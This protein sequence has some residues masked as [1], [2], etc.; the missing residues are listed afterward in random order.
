MRSRI[1]TLMFVDMVGYSAMMNADQDATIQAVRE[2]KNHQ[3]EPVLSDFGGE[4]LK[5]MGDGWIIAF[6]SISAALDSAIQVQTNLYGHRKLKLRIGCHLGEIVEDEDDFYGAGVNITQRIQTEAPPGGVMVS[7]DL[8][9]QLSDDRAKLLNE[10]GTFNLK[11]ISQPV[12]LYQ[13]RP[14]PGSQRKLDDV[15]SIAVQAF[16]FAPV[17]AETEAIAGDLRDQLIVRVSRRKGVLVFDALSKAVDK[18][19]YDLRGRVRMA[20]GR[21]RFTITMTS[22]EDARPVW[23]QTYEAPT[24]DVFAFCDEVLELAEGDLRLQTN[25]F[26][27]D[28]LV[29]IPLEELSVSE[30]RARAANEYYK[31]TMESWSYGLALMERAISLNPL[32]GVSL[33]MRVEAQIMLFG[34]RYQ[35]LPIEL[36]AAYKEDLDTAV[37]QSPQSDY[38]FWTRAVFRLVVLDDVEGA[39]ADLKRSAELNPAY[40]ENYELEG[41]IAMREGDFDG[42]DAAFSRLIERGAQNP[43]QPYRLFMRGVARFC[44]GNYEGAAQDAST[45]SD[46]RPNEA[47]HLKLR[48]M[49]LREM[50]LEDQAE[51]CL[52]RAREL[53]TDPMVTTKLPVMPPDFHWMSKQLK[54]GVFY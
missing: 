44:G 31:T 53:S 37:I 45:A 9:R 20:G 25:A 26:D 34:A 50:R 18:A 29:D 32:D 8:F 33:C 3:L 6:S 27:G 43:L 52:Q 7:E 2:L 22:R 49:A 17:D 13:W 11:N 41:Q 16:E 12:R 30:L 47:G 39:R 38:V 19:T 5:R 54:P 4:I 42:A 36:Q 14:A 28:R 10:A 15:P 24:D 23:S 51:E 48:A 40:L 35:P 1:T 21:G 46:L